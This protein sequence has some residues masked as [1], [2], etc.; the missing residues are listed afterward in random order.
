VA[1]WKA[2]RDVKKAGLE[3]DHEPLDPVPTEHRVPRYL[4]TERKTKGGEE[5]TTKL[6][7]DSG[8]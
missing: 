1:T 4:C 6:L 2:K 3:E 5:K 8:G 7:V